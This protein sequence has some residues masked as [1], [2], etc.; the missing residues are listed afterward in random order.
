[1]PRYFVPIEHFGLAFVWLGVAAVGLVRATPSLAAGNYAAPAVVAVTHALTLGLVLTSIVGALQQL[2]PVAMGV[3]ARREVLAHAAFALLGVGTLAV[4]AGAWEWSPLLLGIGWLGIVSAGGLTW[5]NLLRHLRWAPRAPQVAQA[6]RTGFGCLAAAFA[7]AFVRIG[8]TAGW[9]YVSQQAL[10]VAHVHLA[11]GGFATVVAMGI[12]SHVL[13]MFLVSHDVPRPLAAFAW[14]STAAGA[15]VVA[16][17]S[18]VGVFP[19]EAIGAL[20]MAAGVAAWLAFTIQCFRHRARRTLDRALVFVAFAHLFLAAACLT[21][22]S[23][24]WMNN[25]N[26][27]TAYVALAL[28]GWLSLFITGVASRI[29]PML[30]L[31]RK[32]RTSVPA[33][34]ASAQFVPQQLARAAAVALVLGAA[35]L[36]PAIVSGREAFVRLGALIIVAAVALLVVQ[37]LW[38][39]LPP[40]AASVSS[41]FTPSTAHSNADDS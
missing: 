15:V 20:A 11:L 38:L 2:A 35:V 6:V 25:T 40:A 12:G 19:L 36:P 24:L 4:V 5:W 8:N 26:L 23:L 41:V 16:G 7:V 34:P 39:A 1:M 10:L 22:L 31:A 28:L 29:L 37:H 18:L 21:G 14:R 32:V 30:L 13:P 27:A 9:W 3:A 17:G 33:R